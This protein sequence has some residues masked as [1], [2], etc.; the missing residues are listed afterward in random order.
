MKELIELILKLLPQYFLDFGAVLSTPKTFMASKNPTDVA[1]F[2]DSLLFLGI[3]AVI[4]TIISSPIR[5]SNS[6]SWDD[7]ARIITITFIATLLGVVSTRLSWL[8]VRGKATTRTICTIFNYISGVQIVCGGIVGI[9]NEGT[10][11]LLYPELYKRANSHDSLS[12]V[13]TQELFLSMLPLFILVGVL[14]VWGIVAWGAYRK[15]NATGR[16]RSII[17]LSINIIVDISLLPISVFVFEAMK[18]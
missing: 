12:D 14:F 16:I 4:L 15:V 11:K 7:L 13:P 3:S 5:P 18:K 2:R 10:I 17:A 6:N 9:I 8:F 1:T